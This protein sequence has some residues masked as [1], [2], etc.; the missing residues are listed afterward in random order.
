[1]VSR[2]RR[3]RYFDKRQ[4]LELVLAAQELSELGDPELSP[5]DSF[6]EGNQGVRSSALTY[7]KIQTA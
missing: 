6:E 2:R 3:P 7:G 5:T 4:Q 1:M